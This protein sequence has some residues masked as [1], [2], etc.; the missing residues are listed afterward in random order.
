MRGASRVIA[1]SVG[2]AERL[3][4]MGIERIDVVTNGVDTT[5]FRPGKDNVEGGR[6]LLYAGTASEWQGSE[7]FA[8]AMPRVLD[9]VPDARLIYIGQGSEWER[10]NEL[11]RQLPPGAIELHRT[12]PATEV[13]RWQRGAVAAV[14]SIVP[15][16]GY[17]FAY[18][19]KI[20]AALASGTPVIFAGVGPAAGDIRGNGLGWVTDYEVE[21]V[22]AAMVAA[23]QRD[24]DPEEPGRLAKWVENHHSLRRAG[25]QAAAV[26]VRASRT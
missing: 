12:M 19:T 21:A 14:V 1:V 13:A 22:A 17:D 20:L 9:R 23:F 4:E 3:R 2:V 5:T 10:L 11:A 18:P 24:R 7:I 25:E 6:Y 8:R 26:V 15:G 16:Q